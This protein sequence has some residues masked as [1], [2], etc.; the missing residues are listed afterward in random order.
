[1]NS[2]GS[3]QQVQTGTPYQVGGHLVTLPGT[4]D[5]AATAQVSVIARYNHR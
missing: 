1:M 2:E 4:L 3:R 5:G